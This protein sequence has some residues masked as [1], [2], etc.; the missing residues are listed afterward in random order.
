MKKKYWG[1]M[2]ITVRGHFSLAAEGLSSCNSSNASSP[3]RRKYFQTTF[4]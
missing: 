3:S 1:H 4:I 2:K